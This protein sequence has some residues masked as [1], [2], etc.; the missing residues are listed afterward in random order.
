MNT[1]VGKQDKE[2]RDTRGGGGGDKFVLL[3]KWS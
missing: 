2:L 1:Q 3:N